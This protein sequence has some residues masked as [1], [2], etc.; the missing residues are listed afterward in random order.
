MANTLNGLDLPS[1]L[2]RD[3]A[4]LQWEPVSHSEKR[5]VGGGLIIQEFAR[6]A[7]PMTLIGGDHAWLLY[8]ALNNIRALTQTPNATLTL[9]WNGT[10]YSVVWRRKDGAI[11]AEPVIDY[12]ADDDGDWWRLRA[13]RFTII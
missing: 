4:D 5:T 10:T 12:E 6:T 7:E 8:S 13:L 3:P 1:G 11:E 9:V 2:R